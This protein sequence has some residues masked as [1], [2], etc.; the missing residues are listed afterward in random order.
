[1]PKNMTPGECLNK[2]IKTGMA[3]PAKTE[4]RE[5]ILI[6]INVAS[7]VKITKPNI[8]PKPCILKDNPINTP[9][10]VA[11]PLPPLKR[12]NKVK[13][14]PVIQLKAKMISKLSWGTIVLFKEK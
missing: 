14:C 11:T 6:T 12:K 4:A 13:L 7:Q 10:V 9:N 8:M 5:T 2:I 3:I 1:M